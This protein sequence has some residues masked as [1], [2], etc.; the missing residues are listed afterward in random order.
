MIEAPR[1]G[2]ETGW[3]PLEIWLA[4][5]ASVRVV[6]EQSEEHGLFRYSVE[7]YFG[8]AEED[9]GLWPQGFWQAQSHSG[10]Y[11]SVVGVV[12]EARASIGRVE[13]LGKRDI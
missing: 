1:L 7:Q 12:K 5:V 3:K 13:A 10:L 11:D 8:P 9:E 6:I 4:G 2:I